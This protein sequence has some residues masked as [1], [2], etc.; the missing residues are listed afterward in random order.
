MKADGKMSTWR[1]I[2]FGAFFIL[3][4]IVLKPWWLAIG[5]F[6]VFCLLMMVLYP[7]K[8]HSDQRRRS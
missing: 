1:W 7:G 2:L 6:A 4:P 5:S 3:F 8:S